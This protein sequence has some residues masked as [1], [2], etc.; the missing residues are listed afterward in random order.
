MYRKFDP[1]NQVHSTIM[2]RF[3]H[4]V[5]NALI[6]IISDMPNIEIFCQIFYQ[7]IIKERCTVTYDE[8]HKRIKD[9]MDK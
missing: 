5:Y 9:F 7:K 6:K 4:I 8:M 3:A 2:Y 1:E